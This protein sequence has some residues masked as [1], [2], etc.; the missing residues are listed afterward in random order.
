MIEPSPVIVRSRD[1][2][3]P[4]RPADLAALRRICLL[5][6][7]RGKDGTGRFSDDGIL[8]DVFLEPYLTLAP[9]TAWV[10]ETDGEPVGYLVST[11]DTRAFSD[12]WRAEWTPEY[13]RR[14]PLPE[15]GAEWLDRIADEAYFWLDDGFPAH[16]HI[17]L[18]PEA[19]G[20]GAG[21]AL[22]RELGLAALAAAVPGIHLVMSS[23]NTAA[24]AFYDR[25]GFSQLAVEGDAVVLGIDPRLLV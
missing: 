18:L 15:P 25:L 8:P 4:Y 23:E 3:R 24:R 22:M 14:H 20:Q 16:L 12:R 13:R 9:E 6:G 5:T 2:I 17:D 1:L 10:V 11:L 21:R 19:Q 7:D